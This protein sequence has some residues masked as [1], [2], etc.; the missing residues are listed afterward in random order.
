[1]KLGEC[2]TWPL[3]WPKALIRLDA[4]VR[5]RTVTPVCSASTEVATSPAV[6][7]DDHAE[8]SRAE[9]SSSA[10]VSDDCLA[11][12]DYLSKDGEFN[13]LPEDRPPVERA[14]NT[15]TKKRLFGSQ[16]TPE[17]AGLSEAKRAN[18]AIIS[19]GT[20]KVVAS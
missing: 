9:P 5:S 2:L 17:D 16:D 11:D 3:K 6:A 1:M 18:D 10:F 13:V 7:L 20:L 8:P 19:P 12:L 15:T 14:I 4:I